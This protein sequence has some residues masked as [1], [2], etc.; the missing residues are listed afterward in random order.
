MWQFATRATSMVFKTDVGGDSV[1]LGGFRQYVFRRNLNHTVEWRA[2]LPAGELSPRLRQLLPASGSAPR[3][4]SIRSGAMPR[5]WSV[6][7]SRM[8]GR[9]KRGSMGL[10]CGSTRTIS[11]AFASSGSA[12]PT[13]ASAVRAI[14]TPRR[15]GHAR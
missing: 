11:R 12:V 13:I 9:V 14:Y 7:S 5:A 4:N 3:N 1:D 8:S 2:H 6:S 10:K 15:A